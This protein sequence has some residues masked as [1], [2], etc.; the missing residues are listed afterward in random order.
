VA[1]ALFAD[2]LERMD[3][4]HATRDFPAVKGP[5]YLGVHLRFGTVSIR[6]LAAR[7]AAQVQGSAGARCG[8]AS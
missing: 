7:H 4:Y 1:Q 6:R 3:R 5:S 2:F 8:W